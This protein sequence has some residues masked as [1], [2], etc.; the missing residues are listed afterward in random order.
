MS[1]VYTPETHEYRVD[2]APIPSTTGVLKSEGFIDTTF[3]NEWGRT[4]GSYLHTAAALWAQGHLDEDT[5]DSRLVPYL[6]GVKRYYDDKKLEPRYIEVPMYHPVYMYGFTPDVVALDLLD[7]KTGGKHPST[8]LQMA[9]Y[10]EG[11]RSNDIKVER[12]VAVYLPGDGTYKE[13]VIKVSRKEVGIFLSAL[14][15][16]NWKQNNLK[17]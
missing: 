1:L 17:R 8:V 3:M 9:S 16:M 4:R 12:C 15:C 7:W 2:G 6:D 13:D 5:L 14:A 11:L 10:G